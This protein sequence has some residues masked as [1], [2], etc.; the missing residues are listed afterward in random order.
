MDDADYDDDHRLRST[1]RL[2]VLAWMRL[3]RAYQKIDRASA[4]LFRRW[5]LSVAQF[6]VLAQL[7]ADEGISQ[8]QLA[9]KLLVTKGNVSQ[10]LAKLERRGLLRREQNGRAYRLYLTPEGRA[11]ADA[12][13]PRQEDAVA[14]KFA[15]LTEHE[16]RELLVLLR[17]L[18]QSLP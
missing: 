2:A 8:Q 7:G 3:A 10:L 14:A 16:Q 1:R 13:V 5:D 15:A 18:D 6:D 17:K 4:E 9:D 11:I 12:A